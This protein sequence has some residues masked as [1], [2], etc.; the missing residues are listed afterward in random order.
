MHSTRGALHFPAAE[1]SKLDE[2]LPTKSSIAAA[3]LQ[4]LP[5]ATLTYATSMDSQITILPGIGSPISGPDSKAMTHYLRSKHDAIL[6]GV[7]TA[8]AD[9]PSLNCRLEGVGGYGGGDTL[10]GQPRPVIIDP[11]GRWEFGKESKIF[12]LVKDGKGKAPWIITAQQESKISSQ[13]RNLLDAAGG[14]FLFVTTDETG[15]FSWCDILRALRDEDIESLMIEGGAGIINDMLAR[16]HNLISSIIVTIAPVWLG[17]GGVV[18]TPERENREKEALRLKGVK[19]I[20]LGQDVVCCG[21]VSIPQ[22]EI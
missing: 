6:I 9:N 20:P 18:V 21:R 5:Y 11:K 4:P 16:S 8:I 1:R 19:W 7:N 3:H 12:G 10:K 22:R 17:K 14:K 2:Y 13:K 15:K